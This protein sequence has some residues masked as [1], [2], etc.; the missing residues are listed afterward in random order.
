[1]LILLFRRSEKKKEDMYRTSGTL[2]TNSDPALGLKDS[3]SSKKRGTYT[4]L[5]A[6]YNLENTYLKMTKR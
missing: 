1:L 5:R 2:A 4:R 6:Q 3:L